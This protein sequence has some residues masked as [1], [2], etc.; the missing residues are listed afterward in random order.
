[1]TCARDVANP[2]SRLKTHGR[3]AYQLTSAA[4][5]YQ[6]SWSLSAASGGSGG[7]MLALKAAAGGGG[8]PAAPSL[9]LSESDATDFV[10]GSQVFYRQGASGSFTVTATS[11]GASSVQFPV[12]FG[13]DGPNDTT[14]P[15]AQTYA[16]PGTL[17]GSG[18][19]QVTASNGAGTSP[20]SLFTVTPDAAAPSTAVSCNGAACA[21]PYAAPVTVTLT[22]SDGGGS[23]VASTYYTTDGSDPT[24]SGTRTLYSAPFQVAATSTVKFYSTDSVGNQENVQTLQITINGGGGGTFPF[25]SA[26]DSYV[27][28]SLPTKNYGTSTAIRVDGSPMVRTYLTFTLTGVS[29]TVTNATLRVFAN[30][31]QSVGYDVYSVSDTS[32]TEA[33]LTWN[34]APTLAATK[35]G[36]SGAVAAGTWTT[37]N[38]TALVSGNG[39]ISVALVTTSTT[40][41]SMSSKEGANAPQ[42]VVTTS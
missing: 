42:L 36:S 22:P 39:T 32:W 27:D 23:G 41:L 33:G 13:G 6:A 38:V 28:S 14:S 11:A 25:T 26:A 3:A 12:V 35:T 15:F 29:G 7:A 8:A 20:A 40:A 30:S 19:Y 1:M 10:S 24:T 4:G 37:V 21:N 17:T 2:G 18:S 34:N 31:A 5:S 16:W 9:L